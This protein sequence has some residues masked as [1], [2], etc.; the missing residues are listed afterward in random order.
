LKKFYLVV[1]HVVRILST[2]TLVSVLLET[3]DLYEMV[4]VFQ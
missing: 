3:F 2:R 4:C 1:A